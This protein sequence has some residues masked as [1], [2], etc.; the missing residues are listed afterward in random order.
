MGSLFKGLNDMFT[1]L[2]LAVKNNTYSKSVNSQ[3]QVV[4]F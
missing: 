3:F 2:N 4:L 1:F